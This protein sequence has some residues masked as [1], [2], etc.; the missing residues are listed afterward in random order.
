METLND[1]V[2]IKGLK[3]YQNDDWFKFSL[4]SVLLPNFVTVNKRCKRLLDLCTGNAPIPLIL[5]TRT[6]AQI[7][8]VDIQKDVCDLAEKSIKVNNL[9]KQISILNMDLKD[10]K[11]HYNGDDF[12][13]IT[14][15]PPYFKNEEMSMKN[16]DEHKMLARHE[17][18]VT[19]EDIIKVS[20]YLL[21][22]DGYFAM[23]HRTERF[24]E[25]V[26]LLEKYNL[27][28]KRVQFIYPKE[29]LE[30]NLF[31]IE[32]TKNGKNGVKFLSPLYVHNQDGS[33]KEEIKKVF[34]KE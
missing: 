9:E 11:K 10:L 14:V 16:L 28:P 4:E 12:D 19:L 21:K 8:G 26:H 3:I 5:S 17:V 22:N 32:C 20:V 31:M 27:T 23:V 30:S 15:N 25:I 18:N 1:L 34:Y 33:Y 7:I 6:N 2:G 24:F 29:N 13:V